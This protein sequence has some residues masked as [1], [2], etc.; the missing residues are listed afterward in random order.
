MYPFMHFGLFPPFPRNDKVFV[1]MDF[2]CR[3]KPRWKNVIEPGIRDVLP[4]NHLEPERVDQRPGGDCILSEILEGIGDYRLF[5]ADITTIGKICCK[6]IRNPNVMYE[7]GVAHA[8][9]LPEEVILFKSDDDD[10]GFDIAHVRVY[11]YDPCGSPGDA[12]EFVTTTVTNSLEEL[13][14]AKN[15]AVRQAAESFNCYCWKVLI[16]ADTKDPITPPPP[17]SPYRFLIPAVDKLLEIGA[18]KI[19]FTGEPP[20]W[21]ML[22]EAEYRDAFRYPITEFGKAI[23]DSKREEWKIPRSTK[24][25]QPSR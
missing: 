3:F 14:H 20:D 9:R 21:P 17:Y 12:R 10:L 23:V 13:D 1:A 25:P 24:P 11:D 6:P 2:A 15:L 7:V 5:V 4:K 8:T 16:E 19:K 18:L 22:K